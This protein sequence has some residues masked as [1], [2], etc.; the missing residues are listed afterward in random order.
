MISSSFDPRTCEWVRPVSEHLAKHDV[1]YKSPPEDALQ[2]IPIGSGDMGMLIW[3]EGSRIVAA[4]NKTDLFD[5]SPD[6]GDGMVDSVE[7]DHDPSLR[8]GARLIID[9]GMPVFDILYIEEFDARLRLGDATVTMESQSPFLKVKTTA[10]ASNIDNIIV[11]KCETECDEDISV[12]T[13]LERFGSRPCF[14]WHLNNSRD[15]T[16]GLSGTKTERNYDVILISQQL[17]ELSFVVGARIT[18]TETK[19]EVQNSHV[20]SFETQ[21]SKKISF[22]I[23]I[24]IVTSENAPD[25]KSKVLDNLS[26]AVGIGFYALHASHRDDWES[27]WKKSFL[28]IPNDYL[29]NIWYLNLYYANSSCRGAYP[30]RFNNG[31]WSWNRDVSN[32]VYYFHWNMQNFIWPLHTANHA[33]LA[34]PYYSYRRNSLDNAMIY[35]KNQQKQEGA[36]FADVADRKGRNLWRFWNNHTPGSQ[37]ALLFWKHYLYT[38]DEEFLKTK[39]WPVIRETARYYASLAQKGEDGVYRTMRS[40]AYEGS[41]LFEEVITDTAMIKA[42]MPAAVK[43]AEL[44]G[45]SGIVSEKWREIGLNMNEFHITPMD[46]DEYVTLPHGKCVHKYGIGKG[47]ELLSGNVFTVGKYVMLEGADHEGFNLNEQPDFIKAPIQGLKKG[48]RMRKRSGNPDKIMYYG[49]PDPEFAP[50]FPAELINLKDRNG[51]LYRASVDQ[52][53]LHPDASKDSANICMG[54]CPYPIV[55]ARL[56]LAEEAAQAVM[57]N[58]ETW[59]LY[60]QGF[61]H[62]GPYDVALKDR[63]ERWHTNTVKDVSTGETFPSPA[64]PFRHFTLEAIPIVCTAV[65]EMLLQSHEGFIR[66]LPAAPKDWSGSFMLAAQGGFV[67]ST[68]YEKCKILWASVNSLYGG[69]CRVKNPWEF[70]S[71]CVLALNAESEK[72]LSAISRIKEGPDSIIE[73]ETVA[74]NHYLLAEDPEILKSWKIVPNSCEPNNNFKSMGDAH[75]GLPRM[76]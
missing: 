44:V 50:V 51:D 41:P 15:A 56:G 5:D 46:D 71:G 23:L 53:R 3:T 42:L 45:E 74:G 29:E 72:E 73:F 20:G 2:G 57:N 14:Y 38:R 30:P 54:W 9:F 32:W 63:D 60:C 76:Y 68:Q 34:E 43:C 52:V 58:I 48:D 62:Y 26:R 13:V 49:I 24:S 65:N 19:T 47:K 27:F 55:L 69:K 8:H 21:K 11:V 1:V 28:S 36:F 10:F 31:I 16:I 40:Q 59:Q 17:R 12:K 18:G 67:I 37:I 64:W 25:P 22:E 70:S 4:L 6:N 75:L 39:A 35:A 66:L 61:G 33:E 7:Y